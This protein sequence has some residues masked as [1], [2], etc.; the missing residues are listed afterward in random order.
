HVK[1]ARK[2]SGTPGRIIAYVMTLEGPEPVGQLTASPDYAHYIEH[3]I[4][5]V[6]DAVL[7]FLG[8]DFESVAQTKRQLALF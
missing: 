1:A 2:Q 3:Q 7:R 5:P 4:A 8:T 6:A